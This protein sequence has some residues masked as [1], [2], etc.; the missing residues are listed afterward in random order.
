MFRKLAPVLAAG[1][2]VAVT[3]ACGAG[4]RAQ[5]GEITGPVDQSGVEKAQDLIESARSRP[6]D[7]PITTPVDKPVPSGKVVDFIGCPAVE[8]NQFADLLTSSAEKLGWTL[9]TIATDGSPGSQQQAFQQIVRDAPDGAIYVGTDRSVYE[10]YLPDIEANGTWMVSVCSTDDQG[11]GIDFVICTPDQ[12]RNTGQL[13]AASIVADSEGKANAVY[14]N[15]P[16]FTNLSALQE[17]FLSDME[18]LCPSCGASS[19]DIPLTALGNGVPPLIVGYLRSHP[20]VNY[21]AAAIDSLAL[22][23]PA[24]LKAAG[25]DDVKIIGQGGGDATAQA[26]QTGDQLASVPWPYVETY[27]GALDSIVRHVAGV[28]QV[29]SALPRSW[30]LDQDNIGDAEEKV[31]GMIPVVVGGQEMFHELWGVN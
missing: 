7:I 29:E 22:G 18:D 5:S 20:E 8:C 31:S 24:A 9:R 4:E 19:L 3:S 12:Q 21:I 30:F 11:E 6:T 17:Q 27:L 25:F 23:L 13:M 28:D 2:V 26:I 1:L 10:R 16:A 15:V 14:V